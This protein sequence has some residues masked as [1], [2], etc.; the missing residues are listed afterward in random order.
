MKY[1]PT[2]FNITTVILIVVIIRYFII[3]NKDPDYD[4]HGWIAAFTIIPSFLLGI[5]LLITD[6]I[7]QR[8]YKTKKYL[9]FFM[10]E[11]SIIAGLLI[12]RYV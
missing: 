1:R 3:E 8:V 10:V 11:G 2:P 12:I 4:K 6:F 7:L 9:W 5:V